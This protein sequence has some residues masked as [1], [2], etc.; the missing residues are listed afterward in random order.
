MHFFKGGAMFRLL[1]LCVVCLSAAAHADTR[2]AFVVGNSDYAHAAALRNPGND[3]SL[4]AETLTQLDFT[5]DLQFDQ[6]RADLG[7]N[8]SAFVKTHKGA[9]VML[10]YFA[11]HGM[12]FD[13][14]NYLIPVDAALASEFD[15]EGET[16][17]LDRVMGLM[18]RSAKASLVF[19]DACRDNPLANAFYTQ[20]FSETR[21]MMTRGLAPVQNSSDGAMVVFSA[22]PGQVAFDGEGANSIF[23]ES[24][25]RH[26]GTENA[27]VLSLM[28]RVIRDVKG[29]TGDKQT[30]MV[31]N[32]L[33]TEIYLNLGTGGA[34]AALAFKQEEVIFEAAVSI[35]TRRTWDIYLDKYPNGNF[36]EIA[37]AEVARLGA[38]EMAEAS[39]TEI[40][41]DNSVEVTREVALDV[42][43]KLGLSREDNRA[44]QQALLDRGYDPGSAD[45]VVGRRTRQAIAD[46]QAFVNLP[47]TGVITKATATALGVSLEDAEESSIALVASRNARLYDPEQLAIIETDKRLIEAAK[48]LVG[49]EFVYGYHQDHLYIAVQTWR[50]MSPEEAT[51]YA[52]RAG[53]Y[54]ATISD[55]RENQF[56]FDLVKN[57]QRFWHKHTRGHST[58]FGPSIGL[59]Q[60]PGSLEPAGGWAWVTGEPVTYQNW[61]PGEPGNNNNDEDFAS[62]IWD[63][64]P[65]NSNR[66]HGTAPQWG[67][68]PH[69]PKSLVIEIE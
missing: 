43:S 59:I 6:S 64:W 33:V 44:I 50:L 22:S 37:L 3:A 34:G 18:Q 5:V 2:V 15:I 52:E 12:Q 27:E 10:F 41:D 9:D 42:E 58:T 49:K 60:R 23:A 13:G 65:R 69:S 20:N 31:T 21:A 40:Q 24:L 14:K 4:I 29:G 47:I 51:R 11:G 56:I 8:L 55:A 38:I 7:R 35:G 28:K 25:A 19:I 45:G 26:L 39:G 57:D 32:D 16:I 63:L 46:F 62:F 17:S 67:D 48:A 53:G 68:L 1:I 54:L 30:P 61:S 66:K 36:R